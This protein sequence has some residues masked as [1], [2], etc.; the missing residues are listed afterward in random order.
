VA[1]NFKLVDRTPDDPE[2][3]PWGRTWI[4]WDP[5]EPDEAVWAVNCR[6]PRETAQ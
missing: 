4:G 1:L 3:S 6:R 5:D 2:T